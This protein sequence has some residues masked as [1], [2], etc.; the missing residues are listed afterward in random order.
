MEFKALLREPVTLFFMI[1]LPIILTIVFGGAFGSEITSYGENVLGIDTVVPVNIVFLLA[2]VGLMGIPITVIELKDQDVI[3]RYITYPIK[4]KTYFLSLMSVFSF[5]SLLSTL[6]FAAISFLFYGATWYMTISDVA[7]FILLYIAMIV[8]FDGIGFLIALLIK[9]SRTA[10]MVTSGIFLTL[11]FTSGVALPVD[12]LPSIAQKIAY[13]F[14]MY[15]CIE[16]VQ[17]LWIS[18]FVFTDLLNHLSYIFVTTVTLMLFLG[19]V[20]VKWD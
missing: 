7:I 13:A 10:S 16:V 11:I 15:H 20:R 4:Y 19:R 12:S 17:M 8:I 18:E 5:V 14:P 1:I 9:S 6:L 3:K 2:N